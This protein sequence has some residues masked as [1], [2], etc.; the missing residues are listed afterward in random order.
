MLMGFLGFGVCFLVTLMCFVAAHYRPRWHL[1]MLCPLI[2]FVGLSLFPAYMV[3]RIEIR[4]SVWGGHGYSERFAK[5]LRIMENFQWF[6]PENK[7][8]REAID[9]RLNQNM[10]IGYALER[11]QAGQVEYAQGETLGHALISMIPRA[12]WPGK[13]IYAGSGD[14]V[15]RFTGIKFADG[16]SI[17]IGHVMELCVNF[18]T[19][20]VLVGSVVLG[21]LLGL[22]DICAAR[23][24]IAGNWKSFT[25]WFMI[26]VSFLQVGGNFAEATGL[27]AGSFVLW[28]FIHVF[29]GNSESAASSKPVSG[30]RLFS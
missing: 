22:M 26:G 14:L 2:G 8:H 13:P 12:L 21:L 3:T 16:T 17:G 23:A 28:L 18:G 24:L 20:G 30:T 25:L 27:A 4:K 7:L 15:A 29:L 1:A 11:L 10:F 9:G 5:M 19:M 6:D